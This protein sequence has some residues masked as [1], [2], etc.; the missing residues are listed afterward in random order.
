MRAARITV[1]LVTIGCTAALAGPAA[2][3]PAKDPPAPRPQTTVAPLPPVDARS[4]GFDWA[5]AGIGAAGGVSVV[6]IGLA[7]AAERRR[8]RFAPRGSFTSHS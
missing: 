8:R 2:A 1:P 6:A 7:G 5:A 3:V 4:A